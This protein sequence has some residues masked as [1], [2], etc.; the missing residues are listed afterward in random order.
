METFKKYTEFPQNHEVSLYSFLEKRPGCL[1]DSWAEKLPSDIE[2]LLLHSYTKFGLSP[3]PL[4][5]TVA[6]E[7]F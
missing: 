7:G 3:R 5:V 2:E 4:P 6:P 1:G